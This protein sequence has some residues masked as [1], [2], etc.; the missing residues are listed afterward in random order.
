MLKMSIFAVCKE[1]SD[2]LIKTILAGFCLDRHD[3]CLLVYGNG[4]VCFSCILYVLNRYDNGKS[5]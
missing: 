5:C 2:R 3:G 4:G 1:A